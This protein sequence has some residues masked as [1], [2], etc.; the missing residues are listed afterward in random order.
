M[1]A[2]FF[3]A[4]RLAV[5]SGLGIASLGGPIGDADPACMEDPPQAPSSIATAAAAAAKEARIIPAA[6]ESAW[7]L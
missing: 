6:P 3:V 4:A 7:Q 5:D 2:A 1:P